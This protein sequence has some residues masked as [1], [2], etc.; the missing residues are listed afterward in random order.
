MALFRK[1]K[2]I[3]IKNVNP[4]TLYAPVK[5][6]IKPIELVDDMVFSSKMMGDGIAI[7]PIDGKIYSPVDG[8]ISVVFPTGHVVGIESDS[9]MRVIL[10][11]GIDTVEL[12][13]EG[14]Q[15]YVHVGDKVHAGSF[16]MKI[17]LHTITKNY[18]ATTMMV[19]E[20]SEE[21]H[22]INKRMGEV[23]PGMQVLEVERV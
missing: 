13:G 2:K 20:N 11:I 12:N 18:Q 19:I 21:F 14:F 5:G 1:E 3:D 17:N 16:I 7:E 4:Y 9:G 15:S 10:H 23:E 6:V 8:K 22:F